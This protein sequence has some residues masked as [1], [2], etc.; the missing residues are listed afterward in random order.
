MNGL[1]KVNNMKIIIEYN[2]KEPHIA[3]INIDGKDMSN[4]LSGFKFEF[5]EKN[6]FDWTVWS[7]HTKYGIKFKLRMLY[8]TIK[9]KFK[10]ILKKVKLNE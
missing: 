8:Y 3:F 5:T 10:H 6:G 4:V 7:K 1:L 2:I 9:Q